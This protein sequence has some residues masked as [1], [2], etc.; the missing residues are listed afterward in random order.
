MQV[1]TFLIFRHLCVFCRHYRNITEFT[2]LNIIY[3]VCQFALQKKKAP[4]YG[5]SLPTITS[6]VFCS[7]GGI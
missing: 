5:T 1:Q 3:S 4:M 2:I 6:Q 7:W